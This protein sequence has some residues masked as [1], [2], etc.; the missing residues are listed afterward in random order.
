[1]PVVQ[2]AAATVAGT[3]YWITSF[4][5]FANAGLVSPSAAGISPASQFIIYTATSNVKLNQI[6]L[7]AMATTAGRSVE[8]E[9]YKY[10]MTPGNTT[11]PAGTQII[12]DTPVALTT[13]LGYYRVVIPGN[14]NATLSA[15]DMIILSFKNTAGANFTFY[16]NGTMEF[17]NN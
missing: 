13:A 16:V 14:A 4:N 15:G 8:F 10:T 7:Q 5:A 3:Y 17:Q 11:F 6:N 9:A 12:A 1:M 2:G